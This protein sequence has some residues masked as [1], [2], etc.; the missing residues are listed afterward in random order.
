M[1]R[2][3]QWACYPGRGQFAG[4]PPLNRSWVA[5]RPS[6]TNDRT[7]S[8]ARSTQIATSASS[9]FLDR[10]KDE[11]GRVLPA[12]RASDPDPHPQEVLRPQR[13]LERSQPVVTPGA[14][15]ELDA[16]RAGVDVQ[17]VVDR[18]HMVGFDVALLRD[19][20]RTTVPT[21]S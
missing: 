8:A 3:L 19:A 11:V 15:A 5:D 10:V 13:S 18:D 17:F 14:A 12:R 21:R 9:A 6:A 16:Q 7:A 2:G 1:R 20:R 4:A